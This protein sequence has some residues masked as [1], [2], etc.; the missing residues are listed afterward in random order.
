MKADK[1]R[2]INLEDIEN[3]LS[4]IR[5]SVNRRQLAVYENWT[6]EYGSM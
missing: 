6:Q 2:K 5:P 1:V 4:V 3:A